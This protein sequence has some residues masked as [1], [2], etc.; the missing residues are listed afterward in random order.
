MSRGDWASGRPP[1]GTSGGLTLAV[2]EAEARMSPH[3]NVET[4]SLSTR[5]GGKAARRG[6]SDTFGGAD[7]GGPPRPNCTSAP[8]SGTAR[9]D[10]GCSRRSSLA[11]SPVGNDRPVRGHDVARRD[12]VARAPQ[13]PRLSVRVASSA[14]SPSDAPS[15]PLRTARWQRHSP[16][17]EPSGL[18]SAP[19][20]PSAP[21][22]RRPRVPEAARGPKAARR[23]Q[24]RSCPGSARRRTRHRR[25]RAER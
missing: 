21:S 15:H 10:P 19:A 24:F 18:R 11:P 2:E 3:D 5:R 12:S 6:D 4:A 14:T 25:A 20:P 9:S 1:D 16:R 8:V 23:Q 22:V 17:F 13:G 7:Y